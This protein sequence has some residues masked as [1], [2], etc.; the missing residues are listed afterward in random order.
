[1]KMPQLLTVAAAALMATASFAMTDAE[2]KAEK[3]RIEAQYKSSKAQCK[4]MSG[5]AKDV[6]EEEAK[7]QEKVA[8]AELKH[9]Q[10]PS[11][12]NR[13]AL[14]KAKADAAYEVAEE[15][16]DDLKGNAKDVCEKEAKAEHV[17]ALEAAKV[18]EA[19]TDS[20]TSGTAKAAH[21]SEVRK[22]AAEKVREADYKA[23]RERCDAMSGDAK[24]QCVNDAKRSFGQ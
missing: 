1:M 18:A 13:H 11:E 15:K 7:G 14:A 20:S 5:N 10:D 12:K 2:H 8:K 6:C 22:D 23:A 16:C 3:A 9:R 21:V 19:R 24:D 4:S 17:R